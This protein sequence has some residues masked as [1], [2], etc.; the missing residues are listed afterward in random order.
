[1]NLELKFL[2]FYG[3]GINDI[4]IKIVDPEYYWLRS[5]QWNEKLK[6]TLQL[7]ANCGTENSFSAATGLLIQVKKVY[8]KSACVLY[9]LLLG[10]CWVQ[11]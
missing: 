4:Y 2:P 8:N 5:Q 1:M 9:Y 10:L 6:K 11:L 3:F 7:M